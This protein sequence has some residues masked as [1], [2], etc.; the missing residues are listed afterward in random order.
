MSSKPLKQGTLFSFFNKAKPPAASAV[1]A[2]KQKEACEPAAT[3]PPPQ[4]KIGDRIE[5]YWK[6]DQEY[7]AATV[8]QHRQASSFLE[9]D[10]GQTEWLDLAQEQFRILPSSRSKQRRSIREDDDEEEAEF[11]GTLESDDG[12]VYEDQHDEPKDDVSEED[13]WLVS[14]EDE[15]EERPKKKLKVTKHK[16]TPEL[17]TPSARKTTALNQFGHTP[18]SVI[19]PS[20]QFPPPVVP[21]PVAA[22]TTATTTNNNKV[23]PFVKDAVNPAGSHVHNHLPFLQNPRDLQRRSTDDPQYDPRT[24][25]VVERDW[26]KVMGKEMTDAVKQ[27]WD[28]KSQYFDTVLLFKTGKSFGGLV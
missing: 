4:V 26:V 10:D 6:D 28:L 8:T 27:W 14:D 25:L 1:P 9:Y 2:T 18:K 17:K 20:S 15:E 24:L 3:K 19:T 7:Y 22:T 23:T 16:T 5:V 21:T 12:S 11:D 13:K